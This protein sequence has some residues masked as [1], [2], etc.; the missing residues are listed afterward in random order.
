[1][2]EPNLPWPSPRDQ[3]SSRLQ[4]VALDLKSEEGR[5]VVRK[6]AGKSDVLIENFRPGV[7]EKWGLD[8]ASMEPVNPT[9]VYARLSGYGQTGPY[10][11]KA[12]FASVCEAFGGFRHINGFPDGP[13]VR[14]NISMGDTLAGL[15][16]ALGTVMALLA[17]VCSPPRHGRL[18][19]A[20]L[21]RGLTS[22][23]LPSLC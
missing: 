19:P 18:A 1:M 16:A 14:P 4:S 17:Q 2:R 3:P 22:P 9:L 8:P 20:R 7:L 10:A 23:G 6:L 12:G 13:P 11:S 5:E 21:R 15:H